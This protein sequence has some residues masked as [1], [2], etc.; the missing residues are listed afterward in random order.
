MGFLQ[1]L[2]QGHGPLSALALGVDKDAEDMPLWVIPDKKL[3]VQ[4]VQTAMRDHYEGT[5]MAL[6]S[7]DM[8]GGIWQMPTGHATDV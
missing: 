3:S 6:D 7:A 5:P 1:S 8:G 4:D 2:R